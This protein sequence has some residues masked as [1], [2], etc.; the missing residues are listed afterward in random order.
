MPVGLLN[1]FAEQ[2]LAAAQ[3]ALVQATTGHA[4]PTY[5][6][7]AHDL[8][9]ADNC[10]DG[11]QLTVHLGG[12]RRDRHQYGEHEVGDTVVM[13][14]TY[15]ITLM[16]C[17]TGMSDSMTDPLPATADIDADAGDLLID[18]WALLTELWDRVDEETLAPGLTRFDVE[19][20]DPTPLETEGDCAGWIIPV[21][22]DAFGRGPTGS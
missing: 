4:P 17:V 10:C 21:V 13:K 20:G 5:A 2:I 3:A 22:I 6:Y 8:P 11:G 19:V 1:T 7:V 9:A 18:L 12:L 16:R 15:I 14:A